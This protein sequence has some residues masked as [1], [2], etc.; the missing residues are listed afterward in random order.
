MKHPLVVVVVSVVAAGAIL[1]VAAP[2]GAQ[3]K[4]YPPVPVDRDKEKAQR[5]SLW[6]AATNPAR[7]P[8]GKLL[9]EAAQL[10]REGTSASV[11]EAVKRLDEAVQRLPDEPKAYQMRGEAHLRLKDWAQA[12]RT[13]WRAPGRAST[14]HR[15][16]GR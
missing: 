13:I 16:W 2:A 14:D 5:S 9:F 8:Y 6:E 3:S 12:A 11:L 7:A 1:A 10:L 15:E 4:R